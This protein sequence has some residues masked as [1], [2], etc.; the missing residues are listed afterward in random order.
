MIGISEELILS[1]IHMCGYST[2]GDTVFLREVTWILRIL[3]EVLVLYLAVWSAIQHF[4][5]LQRPSTE[6]AVGNYVTVLI[7]THV[8]YFAR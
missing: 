3:W 6:W 1:G 7:K 8:F 5:E 4:R 2:V